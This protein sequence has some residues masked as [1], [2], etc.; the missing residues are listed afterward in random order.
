MAETWIVVADSTSARIFTP[1]KQGDKIEQVQELIHAASRAQER[2]L[3]TDSPGRVFD[4]E[5]EGRH[6]MSKSVS[7]KEHEARKLCKRLADEIETARAQ[8]RLDRIVLIAAPSLLGELRKMLSNQ[9]SRL[10]V[11]GIDKN[12]AQMDESEIV[13]HLPDLSALA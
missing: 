10:I 7:P 5:G 6:S 12:L 13:K 2:E 11:K 9:S 1:A 8:T 3:A 4:S